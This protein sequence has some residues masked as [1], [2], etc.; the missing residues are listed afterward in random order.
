M[1][2]CWSKGM[3]LQSHRISKSGKLMYKEITIALNTVVN[4]GNLL[5]M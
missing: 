3:K 1:E 4:T 2:R 5:R